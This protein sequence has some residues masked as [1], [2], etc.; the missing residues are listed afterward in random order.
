MAGFFIGSVLEEAAAMV[1]RDT[2]FH[3]QKIEYNHD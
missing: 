1:P 3:L 2:S